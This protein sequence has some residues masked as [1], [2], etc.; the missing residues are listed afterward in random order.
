MVDNVCSFILCLAKLRVNDF[1]GEVRAV[2]VVVVAKGCAEIKEQCCVK[3]AIVEATEDRMDVP[4]L[5]G[6]VS[7]DEAAEE[8]RVDDK[9]VR[10]AQE[11]TEYRVGDGVQVGAMNPVCDAESMEQAPNCDED[12]QRRGVQAVGGGREPAGHHLQIV[13][14]PA[15]HHRGLVPALM[16]GN[17]SPGRVRRL[18]VRRARC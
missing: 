12:V 4:A 18:P 7:D 6:G 13:P 17:Q 9:V 3:V 16:R 1:D 14:D 11:V 8:Q 2:F 5:R 15:G 10:G